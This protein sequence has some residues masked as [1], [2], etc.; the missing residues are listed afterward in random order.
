LGIS[1]AASASKTT[2]TAGIAD[3]GIL[4][5]TP[6]SEGTTTARPKAASTASASGQI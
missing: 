5:P 2:I 6:Y 4:D 3:P 1:I